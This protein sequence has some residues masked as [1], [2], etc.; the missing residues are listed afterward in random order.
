MNAFHSSEDPGIIFSLNGEIQ[1]TNNEFRKIM[2]CDETDSILQGK[3]LIDII[4]YQDNSTISNIK[5]ITPGIY[6]I[7]IEKKEIEIDLQVQYTNVLLK[8][9][10]IKFGKS[11]EVLIKQDAILIT[12]K[13]LNSIE[14]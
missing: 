6:N 13:A 7:A 3:L 4:F 5:M 12:F 1:L 14:A 8:K 11:N 2:N 9:N 10:R